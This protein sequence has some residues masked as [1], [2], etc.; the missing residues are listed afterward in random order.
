MM[1]TGGT[2]DEGTEGTQT[3]GNKRDWG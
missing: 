2:R 1:E 3:A